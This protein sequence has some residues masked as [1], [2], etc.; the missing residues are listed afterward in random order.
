MYLFQQELIPHGNK[1][2][3]AFG[4]KEEAQEYRKSEEATIVSQKAIEDIKAWNRLSAT[5]KLN[6][7][8]RARMTQASEM[9]GQSYVHAVTGASSTDKERERIQ[10][11]INDAV[12]NIVRTPWAG[13]EQSMD[14][15]ERQLTVATQER[16]NRG[17]DATQTVR[18]VADPKNKGKK[19]IEPVVV[20]HPP[21]P[22]ETTSAKLP[23]PPARKPSK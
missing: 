10:S 16:Q 6:P 18:I 5:E 2:G 8:N 22:Q 15:L 17:S 23:P 14:I 13:A 7:I 21:R 4:S 11:R 1:I 19:I 12:S 9:L 20:L 3:K